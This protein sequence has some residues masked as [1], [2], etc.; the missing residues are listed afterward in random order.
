MLAAE[1]NLLAW[2]CENG[3]HIFSR[4]IFSM[5]T[6][7]S[8][9]DIMKECGVRADEVLYELQRMKADKIK[10]DNLKI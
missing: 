4:S 9:V 6:H 10:C 1:V 5:T 3:H 2:M 7:G 8:M